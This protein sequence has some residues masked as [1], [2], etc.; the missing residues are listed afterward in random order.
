MLK[1]ACNCIII[2]FGLFSASCSQSKSKEILHERGAIAEMEIPDTIE[3]ER[4]GVAKDGKY[5]IEHDIDLRG[6]MCSIPHG[7][8]LIGKRGRIKNGTLVGNNTRLE[9]DGAVFDNVR[10]QGSWDVPY[11]TTNLFADLNYVNSLRDVVALANPEQ[12]NKIVINK[13]IYRVRANKDA[14]VCIALCSNTDFILKGTI[15]LEP[16]DF[17]HYNIVQARGKGINIKGNGTIIGDKHTHTG[18]EG[19]WG[20]GINLR[21]AVNANVTGLTIKDCWGDCIYVGGRSRNVVIEKCK[22]DNGRR[23]GV[24]V[25]KAIGVTIRDCIITNVG[26]TNPQYAIDIEP[27]RKDSVDKILIEKVVVK[28]CEG[29]FLVVRGAQKEGAVTP[30]IGGVTI[31]NC[32]VDCK[33][34]YPVRIAR[35]ETI[36]IENCALNAP[37]GLSG[38]QISNTDE[39]I[40]Q[41]NSLRVSYGMIDKLKNDLREFVGKGRRY[42]IDIRTTRNNVIRNNKILQSGSK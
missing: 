13:G 11:I 7:I 39:A 3:F 14:D 22:L 18:T 24:S 9:A 37:Q 21:G 40:V 38:I 34:K 29:G 41:N 12:K 6:G 36:R 16:N 33:S 2:V 8:T 20:M 1:F 15:L 27:N 19:E 26:G 32:E 31:K 28:N 35:C 30:W 5:I 10:I 25:T 4:I 23:Q 42:P 17:K